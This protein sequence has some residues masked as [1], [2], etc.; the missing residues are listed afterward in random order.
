MMI[1]GEIDGNSSHD[2]EKVKL[3]ANIADTDRSGLISWRETGCN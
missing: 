1:P 3:I 2:I